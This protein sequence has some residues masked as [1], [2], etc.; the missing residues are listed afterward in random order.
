MIFY[1][2]DTLGRLAPGKRMELYHAQTPVSALYPSGV[3]SFGERV[4][5]RAENAVQGSQQWYEMLL[6]YYRQIKYPHLPSRFTCVFA[7]GCQEDSKAWIS[8]IGADAASCPVYAVESSIAYIADAR[9][10]DCGIAQQ[11]TLPDLLNLLHFAE[12]YFQSF[13]RINEET[14]L[15]DIRYQKPEILLVPPVYVLH[16]I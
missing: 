9:F 12:A 10:L 4:F 3:S 1:H 13:L 5:L 11:D 8:R 7:S 2:A 6:D 16:Q 15:R 14:N